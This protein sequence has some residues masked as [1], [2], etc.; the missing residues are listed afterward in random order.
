MAEVIPLKLQPGA[1]GTGELREFAEGDTLPLA[2]MPPEIPAALDNKVDKATGESLM[3]DAERTKLAGIQAGAQVNSVTSVAGRT[4]DVLLAKGDVGLGNVDNTSDANKPVST[5][6]Q[7]A[8]DAKAPLASPALTGTPTAPTATAGTNTTQIASTAFVQASAATKQPLDATLTALAGVTTSADQLIYATGADTFATTT[9]T[10]QGRALLDDV[11][12]A[13]QRGT[14]GLGSAATRTALGTTGSLYSR[15][16]ILGTVS[17]S[18]GVPT[19]AIIERG[20]NANGDYVRY[21]DGTQICTHALPG[22]TAVSASYAIQGITI[23]RQRAM[24]TFPAAF[25][26]TPVVGYAQGQ[27]VDNTFKAGKYRANSATAATFDSTSFTSFADYYNLPGV[28]S[29]VGRWF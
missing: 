16:S 29:A 2:S 9:L 11:D 14:L 23:Y 10:A 6:Q 13:G 25:I 18:S 22:G 15:D 27:N 8:L 1:P 20:S 7:N 5:A 21:A 26:A 12:A 19:G 24:W 3:L 4:G 17:Q 28:V